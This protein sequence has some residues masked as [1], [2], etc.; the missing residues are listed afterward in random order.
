MQEILYNNIDKVVYQDKSNFGFICGG[1]MKKTLALL[2][3]FAMFSATSFQTISCG[4]KID[5]DVDP[6][7]VEYLKLIESFKAE[8][9]SII[10][11]HIL[12][13]RDEMVRIIKNSSDEENEFFTI[14]NIKEHGDNK[15]PNAEAPKPL[16]SLDKENILNAF[17][18]F[19]NVK[20]L[21]KKIEAL[22][23]ATDKYKV[24]IVKN[25]VLNEISFNI[26]TF[27]LNYS[28]NINAES[29]EVFVAS[30]KIDLNVNY[31]YLDFDKSL[32]N[33]KN[34][35]NTLLTMTNDSVLQSGIKNIEQNLGNDLIQN[36]DT[37][38]WL[39][40]SDIGY[41]SNNLFKTFD[42]YNE[43]K[44]MGYLKNLFSKN[45]FE[46]HLSD[47]VKSQNYFSDG[48]SEI[49]DIQ[50]DLTNSN[51]IKDEAVNIIK[52]ISAISNP[53]EYETEIRNQFFE[54]YETNSK[55]TFTSGEKDISSEVFDLVEGK[56]E[57]NYTEFQIALAQTF[58]NYQG[59]NLSKNNIYSGK[60][61]IEGISAY[62]KN[63][64]FS[65]PIQNLVLD[66]V[67]RL[68]DEEISSQKLDNLTSSSLG[69]AVYFNIV[70]G[71]KSFQTTLGTSS[72][73]RINIDTYTNVETIVPLKFLG[74]DSNPEMKVNVWNEIPEKIETL[75]NFDTLN[76]ALSLNFDI[77]SNLKFNLLNQGYQ[78]NFKL[79]FIT[80]LDN[81]EIVNYVINQVD[82][83]KIPPRTFLKYGPNKNQIRG[84]S[85]FVDYMLPNEQ[86]YRSSGFNIEFSLLNF[87]ISF[88]EFNSRTD[89][90]SGQ[91]TTN[92]S[93]QFKI[94]EKI[95]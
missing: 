77:L 76:N 18:V 24:I 72:E 41:D 64:D 32:K 55:K 56:L 50:M 39:K 6:N 30:A 9:S 65:L 35:T 79:N 49:T 75:E 38:V 66:Y 89:S 28:S 74:T 29:I 15:D 60:F 31:R 37:S 51:I 54:K 20:E 2:A 59:T 42:V 7:L 84:I 4:K 11:Q 23:T 14:E 40:A 44:R 81:G 45:T 78:A 61:Y 88:Y 70:S 91:P 3:S 19:F 83:T 71:I 58:E 92:G 16:S 90:K 47:F 8:I 68:N 1:C 87:V 13:S 10:F 46:N 95:T 53:Q 36:N 22:A 80:M 52:P 34:K 57:K 26:D 94:V 67:F 63:L 48:E 43:N 93:A 5:N 82:N 17:I 27:N 73:E 62:F 85:V 12:E 69:E 33:I 25:K 21:T 86:P